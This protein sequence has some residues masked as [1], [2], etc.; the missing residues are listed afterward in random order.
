MRHLCLALA[1]HREEEESAIG[2]AATLCVSAAREEEE[3]HERVVVVLRSVKRGVNRR[4]GWRAEEVKRGA[5][6][7]TRRETG[8]GGV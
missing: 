3:L 5:P 6:R 1:Q 2:A 8:H 4:E 7:W